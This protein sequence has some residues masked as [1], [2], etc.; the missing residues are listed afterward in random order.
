MAG[1][2]PKAADQAANVNA[3]NNAATDVKAEGYSTTTKILLGVAAAAI[4]VIAGAFAEIYGNAM[5]SSTAGKLAAMITANPMLAAGITIGIFAVAG[6]AYMISAYFTKAE[7]PTVKDDALDA[8][9]AT[10]TK[11]QATFD[12]AKTALEEAK[13]SALKDKEVSGDNKG[14][15]SAVESELKG[16]NLAKFK[17]LTKDAQEAFDEAETALNDAKKAVADYKPA[18]LAT[19]TPESKK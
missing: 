18:T 15:K 4:V 10:E 9:K 7:A 1:A 13:K 16:D 11:A 8:L 17:E 6:A 14:K 12:T 19:A 3:I 5:V 2:I